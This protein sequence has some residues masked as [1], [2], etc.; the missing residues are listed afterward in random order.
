MEF[1]IGQKIKIISMEGEPQYSGKEGVINYIDDIGQLHGTWGG[2]AV[3]PE[4]DI[5][6]VIND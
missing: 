3:Q 2:L 1:E 4:R 6:E 5:I